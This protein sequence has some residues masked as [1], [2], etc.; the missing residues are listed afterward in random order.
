MLLSH[1]NMS[2]VAV[3]DEGVGD[4]VVYAVVV[5]CATQKHCPPWFHMHNCLTILDNCDAQQSH[6]LQLPTLQPA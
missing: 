4:Q 5:H 2:N 1:V 3:K 6:S